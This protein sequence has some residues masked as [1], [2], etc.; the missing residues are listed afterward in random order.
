MACGFKSSMA[1]CLECDGHC[2][3]YITVQMDTPEED[4]EFEELKW[5]LCHENISVYIDNEGDWCVEVKTTCK[6]Q[7]PKT[8]LCKIYGKRPQV[9]AD[10]QPDECEGNEEHDAHY[11]RVFH[12]MEEIDE[13][14]REIQSGKASQKVQEGGKETGKAVE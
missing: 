4:I 11:Q 14:R 5:F 13:Y 1:K 3:K 10:H 7:D 6:F 8:N 9:C 12:T 2:C